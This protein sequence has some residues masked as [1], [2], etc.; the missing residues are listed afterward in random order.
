M[1]PLHIAVLLAGSVAVV[2]VLVF[3]RG[4]FR[5]P[6]VI[7]RTDE[8]SATG[9]CTLD[10]TGMTCAACTARVQRVL[11]ATEGVRDANVN[12]M[13]ESAVVR[14]D[15]AMV[16]PTALVG[17]VEGTGFGASIPDP[18]RAAFEAQREHDAS[19]ASEFRSL[20]LRTSA[21]L[22]LAATG[23]LLSMPL[24]VSHADQRNVDPFLRFAHQH[25]D[26]ALRGVW[27]GL[28]SIPTQALVLVLLAMTVLTMVWSGRHFYT[29]A[30]T[31]LRQRAADMNTLVAIGSLSAFALSLVA[32]FA[33]GLFTAQGLAPAVYYEA[34]LFIVA[35]ILLGNTFEARAKVR[36]SAAL[37][38]L[39]DL[40]PVRARVERD[41][42]VVEIDVG[43]LERDDLVQVRPGERIPVDGEVVGGTSAVDESMLTGESIPVVKSVGD[44]VIG[45]TVNGSGMLRVR[46]TSLGSDSVLARIVALVR[47]AQGSRAPIQRLVDRVTGVFVPISISIAI[48]TFVVWFLVGGEAAVW[49]ALIAAV[50]VLVIACPCAMGLAVPTAVL[51][52]T[53]RG[54]SEGI[55]FDGG[56]P[57]QRASAVT[58]VVFDKTGTLTQ[59]RPEVVHVE[60]DDPEELLGWAAAVE[61][62]SEHPLAAAILRAAPGGE[63]RSAQDFLSEAGRGASASVDGR[64]VRVGNAAFL[65]EAGLELRTSAS[66]DAAREG[67]TVVHVGLDHRALGWIAI[68]DPVRE[69]AAAAVRAL[70]EDGLDVV[71]LSGDQPAT[72]QAVARS[73]GID[74]VVA[75]VLPEGKVAE[76]RR[77][78]SGG[79]V[80]AMVG[81]GVNDA[82]AL[83]TADLGIA[84]GA[85]T[86]VA[87][88]AAGVTLLRDDP[89]GAVR[90]LRLGRGTLRVMR[91]NLAW[92]FLYNALAIPVAAGVLYPAFGL[93]LSPVLASAAMATSSV[94][95][96]SNSLRLHRLRLDH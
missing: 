71:L 8:D 10:V 35:L 65:R 18:G 96:V 16:T 46:A 94:S 72:A 5:M 14:Y 29:G 52:A 39:V 64:T 6:E 88:E 27:P 63:S 86:D 20:V 76:I 15:A 48:A 44:D 61:A 78:Q 3:F 25:I 17:A 23:M 9:E 38:A 51:V 81:D 82:P 24:M 87:I 66:D 91:Q 36:T 28:Y 32:S 92:A 40:Q 95:V 80:V 11:V 50:S 1:S 30:V 33:P 41:G 31:A 53:G 83:A 69:S 55:L 77:L 93:L 2:G 73:V 22:I 21:A 54:A 60:A 56:E 26:P 62:S 90:A 68:A 37:R 43:E 75:G 34:V 13:M 42:A 45:G 70:R 57:L 19:M 12:L 47:A 89:M 74:R 67:R 49:K 79:A 58:T 84:M 85:G 59:G 7:A 4:G